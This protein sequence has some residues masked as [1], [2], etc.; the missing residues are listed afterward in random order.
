MEHVGGYFLAL[1]L[2]DRDFQAEAKKKG[3]PWTLA[4]GQDNFCP[5]THLIEDKIDPYGVELHLAV[6]G[7]V[8]QKDLT[9]GMHFK[10]DD[11]ISYTSKFISL[12][13]GDLILTGTPEGVGPIKIGDKI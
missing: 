1:D 5:I 3:F 6:N 11:L 4:K 12:S 7:Q 8:R 10:I 9:S 2:T 13:E